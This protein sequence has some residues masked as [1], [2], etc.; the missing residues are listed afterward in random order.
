MGYTHYWTCDKKLPNWDLFIIKVQ[1][2]LDEGFKKG[3]ICFESDQPNHRPEA[4]KRCIMFN[5]IGSDGHETFYMSPDGFS[6]LI[7]PDTDSPF[8]GSKAIR[9]NFCKTARKGYDKYVIGILMMAEI[10][11]GGRID[12]SSDGEWSEVKEKFIN[13]TY[14][15][16]YFIG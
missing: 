7:K 14:E 4:S 9:F 3:I 8:N 5:G 13:G 1:P 2:I 10:H 12:I 16:D 6:S 11:F 15:E